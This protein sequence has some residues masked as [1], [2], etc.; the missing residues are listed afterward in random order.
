VLIVTELP[1]SLQQ[2]NPETSAELPQMDGG[3]EIREAIRQE[4]HQPGSGGV[5]T[6]TPVRE[7]R[8]PWLQ[9]RVPHGFEWNRYELP[10]ESLPPHLD[11][12]RI[13]QLTDLHFKAFWSRT[14]DK[15]ADR[16]NQANADVVLI[17]GDFVDSKTHGPSQQA[18][19]AIRFVEKLRARL[20]IYGILGNHD[21]D[22]VGPYLPKSGIKM[23]N[24]GPLEI[25]PGMEFIAIAEV[26]R[27][28]FDWGMI[29]QIEPKQPG[30]VRI[31]AT[32]YPDTLRK[33]GQIRP[34]IVLAGHTHGGQICLPGGIP[35][36]WHD[37]LP[38]HI[39]HGVHRIGPT[40]LV[41]SRGLGFTSL[42]VRAWCPTEVI[43]IVLRRAN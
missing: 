16:V 3:D 14:Y 13:V 8:G 40:W 38:K 4:E 6:L 20:G 19:Y 24:G 11:G 1:N 31:V 18:P 28:D 30:V 7:R 15:L 34:D 21:G 36:I 37:S 2:F 32:H 17:T 39:C 5:L 41:V 35:L 23:L 10:I 25:T 33:L 22:L 26:A 12:F 9:F 42:P 43:E 29:D 27:E